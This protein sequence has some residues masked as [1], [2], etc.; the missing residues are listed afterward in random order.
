MHCHRKRYEYNRT[1]FEAHVAKCKA[2][3]GT[4]A[5]P[6]VLCDNHEV[7]TEALGDS[8][9]FCDTY[10]PTPRDGDESFTPVVECWDCPEV[11]TSSLVNPRQARLAWEALPTD[12]CG[13]C[14]SQSAVCNANTT[15]TRRRRRRF[16]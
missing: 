10:C 9:A 13:K 8:N 6:E 1:G 16:F 15:E 11:A 7:C 14:V 12:F 5:D 4:L 2:A 3:D